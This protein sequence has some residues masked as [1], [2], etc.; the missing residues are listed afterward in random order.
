MSVFF[1]EDDVLCRTGAIILTRF[2]YLAIR[3]PTEY[4]VVWVITFVETTQSA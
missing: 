4:F 2:M 3:I 1:P